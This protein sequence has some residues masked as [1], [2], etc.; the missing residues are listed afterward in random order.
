L[1]GAGASISS[2]SVAAGFF[3]EGGFLPMLGGGFLLGLSSSKDIRAS[4][5]TSFLGGAAFLG[6]G[7][8]QFSALSYLVGLTSLDAS[9]IFACFYALTS[10][11]YLLMTDSPSLPLRIPMQ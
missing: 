1:G 4:S 5:S 9:S 7:G 6:G 3:F 2:S 11:R 10:L 8:F